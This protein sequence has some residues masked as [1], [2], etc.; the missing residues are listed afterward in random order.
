MHNHDIHYCSSMIQVEGN[1]EEEAH[2][3]WVV[4]QICD[5][6]QRSRASEETYIP[7]ILPQSWKALPTGLFVASEMRN[8]FPLHILPFLEFEDVLSFMQTCK[9]A[10][11]VVSHGSVCGL[12][13]RMIRRHTTHSMDL[14]DF[15]EWGPNMAEFRKL[16]VSIQKEVDFIQ[17]EKFTEFAQKTATAENTT[18]KIQMAQDLGE[19]MCV[20]NCEGNSDSYCTA[21]CRKIFSI[22]LQ[23]GT[24]V[25]VALGYTR[26]IGHFRR[27]YWE[28][29]ENNHRHLGDVCAATD[30]RQG[31]IESF[32][33][34][35]RTDANNETRTDQVYDGMKFSHVFPSEK[36]L[37]IV[38]N[39]APQWELAELASIF[40]CSV[41]VI[42]DYFPVY[43]EDADRIVIDENY[44]MVDHWQNNWYDW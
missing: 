1:T 38:E 25:S 2:K 26:D 35:Q 21:E 20:S 30:M 8:I 29:S 37:P 22:E 12:G 28:Q 27:G 24:T 9:W 42:R 13:I 39:V 31:T 7:Y 41:S 15:Y 23:N 19:A 40:D 17:C 36:Q 43:I 10:N 32:I 5:A 16:F 18:F 34:F 33:H 11:D 6:F 14:G 44:Q 4:Y 3:R